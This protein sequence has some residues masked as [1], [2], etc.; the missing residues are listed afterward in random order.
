MKQS[1]K[2]I[3]NYYMDY[4]EKDR[5]KGNWGQLEF[6]R[7]QQIIK[8]YIPP[9][10][11]IIL[12]I[13]GAAGEYSCWL[14][15]L[16]YKVHLVDPVAKHIEQARQA[17]AKQQEKPITNITIGDA[18]QLPFT[19]SFADAALLM[20]PLYHL[21][22]PEERLKALKEAY[23]VLK[24]SGL[25]FAVA[26]S[27]F[28]SIIDG[29]CS[30]YYQDADFRKIIQQDLKNGQHRNP[31]KNELYFTDAFFH[32]PEELRSETEQAGF[33]RQTIIGIEGIGYMM[34]NFDNSWNNN[35]YRDFLLA[36]IQ[37]LETEPAL[38]GAS[39]H[40]MCVAYKD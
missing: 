24:K 4:N 6:I 14:A 27:Q 35:K 25:M 22:E 13:G 5:L 23:R 3:I 30:G 26:I 18:R 15:R 2:K 29:L 19:D 39:P 36:I 11:A 12:D 16:G 40:I 31:T 38:I 28:A 8:R 21:C 34:K 32:H 17:S 33:K 37:K 10:P 9:P 1:N 20:G 7:S